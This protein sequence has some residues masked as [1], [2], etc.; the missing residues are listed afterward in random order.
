MMPEEYYNE[1]ARGK[2]CCCRRSV[3]LL[4]L[5]P[6]RPYAHMNRLDQRH[7]QVLRSEGHNSV[8]D[9]SRDEQDTDS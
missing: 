4:M 6:G 8:H 2:S 3:D 5:R 7:P 9:I 1:F